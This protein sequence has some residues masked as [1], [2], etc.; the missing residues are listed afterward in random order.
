M[1]NS[2][3]V[4]RAVSR[5]ACSARIP[6]LP[7]RYAV[8]PKAVD[9]PY[10]RYADAG[11]ALEQGFP[12]L[13][14]SAYTLRALRAGYVYV[15]MAGPCGEKLVIHEHDGAGRYKEL[16][17]N[18]L[19]QYHRRDRYIS[20]ASSGWV[21]A[22][23]YQD[24]AGEVWIG[25][26][27]H[28]W[29]NAMTARI[30]ASAAVRRRHM[31]ALDIPELIAGEP[32]N[33]RQAHVLPVSALRSWVEDFKPDALRMS[34]DWSSHPCPE[35]MPCGTLA[36]MARHYPATQPRIPAVIALYDAE[37]I[38]MDL[39]LS[40]NAYQHAMRDPAAPDPSRHA[41]GGPPESQ[42]KVPV[43]YRYDVERICK[44]S[45][46][47]HHKSIVA[48]LLEK[49]L[50]T[51]YPANAPDVEYEA[52]VRAA[53]SD[54]SI[55]LARYEALTNEHYSESG[56]GIYDSFCFSH[57]WRYRLI[58]YNPRHR[59]S[60]AE[61][62]SSKTYEFGAGHGLRQWDKFMSSNL[63]ARLTG[64]PPIL[65]GLASDIFKGLRQSN[66]GD[67]TAGGFTA[68]SGITISIGSAA[69][70]EGTLAIIGPTIVIPFAGWGAVVIV[71]LGATLLAAGLFLQAKATERLHSPLE[72]WAARSVFGTRQN[73][74]EERQDIKLDLFRKLPRFDSITEE[75]KK[76]YST[77]YTPLKITN[78]QAKELQLPNFGSRIQNISRWAHP[79]W[80][81]IV[82]TGIEYTASLGEMT[83]FLRGF[84][85]GQSTWSSKTTLIE[86]LTKSTSL[87]T[88]TPNCTLISTGLILNFKTNLPPGSSLS[89]TIEYHPR[90]GINEE[91]IASATLTL[92]AHS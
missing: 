45:K 61:G 25:Y 90:A 80:G 59:P 66:N 57:I 81:T 54:Q 91:N 88:W 27:S 22:D 4:S 60:G 23:T 53:N 38:S 11:F 35:I 12:A 19:E 47:Y 13:H 8:V 9:A 82:Q 40:A 79:D 26:S 50:H 63:F 71:A 65:F 48:A 73:D 16:R 1:P 32:T 78:E 17:Y 46:D 31:Q 56:S 6:I 58:E 21:W 43:C 39:G 44:Q 18:G 67:D 34:L 64:Y 68:I 42:E 69:I 30:M 28:L 41:F 20:G 14:Q 36:S 84:V 10:F 55:G 49:T 86:A 92:S 15:Y 85:L 76:W 29:S 3:T 62:G 87:L 52:S 51:L 89:L 75:I 7:I 74:G 70:L 5:P 2:N 37:G 33:S 83:I 24:T 72:L 77:Y